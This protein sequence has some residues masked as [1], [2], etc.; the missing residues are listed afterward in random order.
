M[1]NCADFS[2]E[3]HTLFAVTIS[4]NSSEVLGQHERRLSTTKTV[5]LNFFKNLLTAIG[6]RVTGCLPG[7]LL[8]NL[9]VYEASHH[10]MEN[11]KDFSRVVHEQM[12]TPIIVPGPLA[13]YP[14]VVWRWSV[15]K[16]ARRLVYVWSRADRSLVGHT[17]AVICDTLSFQFQ[18]IFFLQTSIW[19]VE[20]RS[21]AHLAN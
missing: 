14:V 8:L 13:L 3:Y 21:F 12:L 20:T 18:I 1:W 15:Q 9:H 19:V 4:Q 5:S 2:L 16:G 10:A 6:L 7:W 11:Y 17:C